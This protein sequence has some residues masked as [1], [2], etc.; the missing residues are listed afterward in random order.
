MSAP[1]EPPSISAVVPTYNDV[2]RIGDAL[3]SI[4]GQ[5]LAPA[6]IVVCDDGSGDGTEQFVRDFGERHA[7]EV[8]VRYIRLPGHSGAWAA[9]NKAI[10]VSGG[11]W[12]ANCDSDDIWAPNKLERQV[13]FIRE[14]SGSRPISV[15]GTYGY[16]IND[17]KKVIS[18]AVMG[19]TTEEEYAAL[20]RLGEIFY[21]IHSSAL[22]R[23]SDFV[24]VGGYTPEYGAADDF[25]FFCRMAERGVVIN[26]PEPLVYYRKRAGSVI[27]ARFWDLRLGVERLTE[28]ERRRAAGEAPMSRDE[29]AAKLAA[30]PAARRFRRLTYVWGMYYYRRGATDMVNGHRIRGSAELVL[31]FLLDPWRLLAGIRNAFRY[32]LARTSRAQHGDAS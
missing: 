14:W 31:A 21:I 3:A 29:F 20:R 26:L 16:N 10:E 15:L 2:S 1:P 28:N 25:P 30:E 4:A 18:P 7:G 24:A 5:T 22:F 6:E 27:I 11:D 19:P 13:N 9:R 17:A 32:R 8:P 23:R 12:I